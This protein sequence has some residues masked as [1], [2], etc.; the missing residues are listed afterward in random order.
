MIRFFLSAPARRRARRVRVPVQLF[1]RARG[2]AVAL[3]LALSIPV[4]ALA[5]ISSACAWSL[6][7]LAE[8]WEARLAGRYMLEIPPLSAQA[9]SPVFGEGDASD[10]PTV[11]VAEVLAHVASFAGVAEVRTVPQ[12]EVRAL[13]SPWLPNLSNATTLPSFHRVILQDGVASLAPT[14]LAELG[15]LAPGVR[16]ERYDSWNRP[17]LEAAARLRLLAQ[18]VAGLSVLAFLLGLAFAVR[19]VLAAEAETV[20]L[21]HQMGADDRFV[22]RALARSAARLGGL[23]GT[24]GLALALPGLVLLHGVFSGAGF[25]AAGVWWSLAAVPLVAWG[26]AHIAAW[27]AVRFAL[28]GE[29]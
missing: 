23:G 29:A 9:E 21:L 8:T 28:H 6:G 25:I 4:V 5:V 1:A 15:S 27:A 26:G 18:L 3:P 16:L 10:A 20:R 2:R 19:S 24:L 13:L 17:L 22:A 11:Y 12:A 14:L 7:S